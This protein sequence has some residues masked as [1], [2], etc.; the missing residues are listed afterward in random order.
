MSAG[1]CRSV[2]LNM[3]GTA[4]AGPAIQPPFS[5]DKSHCGVRF[6]GHTQYPAAVGMQTTGDI[7]RQYRRLMLIEL[8]DG[9]PVAASTG[10][11]SPVPS[12]AS[13]NRP[14]G[15]GSEPVKRLRFTTGGQEILCRT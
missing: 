3:T 9:R 8:F 7:R 5:P 15:A 4:Y 12:N 10:R 13:T 6:Y 14:A 1:T 11:A 2:K